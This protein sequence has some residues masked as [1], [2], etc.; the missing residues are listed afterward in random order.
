M[1]R[2]PL[3]P[4]TTGSLSSF[5]RRKKRPTINIVFILAALLVVGGLAILIMW[6]SGPDQP[7]GAL[8][9]T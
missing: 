2:S 8:F 5:R 9:A 3:T 7:L 6:L 4:S 1:N